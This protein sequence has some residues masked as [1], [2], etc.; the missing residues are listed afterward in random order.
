MEVSG[1]IANIGGGMGG[2]ISSAEPDYDGRPSRP[3]RPGGGGGGGDSAALMEQLEELEEALSAVILERDELEQKVK[4][5]G[6]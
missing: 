5:L 2:Q 1:D 6:G 4:S 3:G